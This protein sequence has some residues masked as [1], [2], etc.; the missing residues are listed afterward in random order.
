MVG[1]KNEIPYKGET[2]PQYTLLIF[3]AAQRSRKN[4]V[5][6]LLINAMYICGSMK[7]A[8]T[9]LQWNLFA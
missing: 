8:L 7:A 5:E 9:Y 1:R 6:Y 3:S 4:H 2:I